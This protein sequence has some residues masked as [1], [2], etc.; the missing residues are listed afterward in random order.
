MMCLFMCGVSELFVKLID[1]NTVRYTYRFY[2]TPTQTEQFAQLFG[3]MR[4]TYN[5]VLQCGLDA[6]ESGETDPKHAHALQDAGCAQ[7]E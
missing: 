6:S 5:W 4:V 1:M 2:P 3:C 7:K